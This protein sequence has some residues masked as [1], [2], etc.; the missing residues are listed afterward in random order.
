MKKYAIIFLATFMS[1]VLP[2]SVSAEMAALD[3]CVPP[4]QSPTEVARRWTPVLQYL[5]E[6]SG[7]L[8]QLKTAKDIPTY[9]QQVME[10]R[11]DIA[12]MS[13]NSYVAANKAGGYRAFAKEKGGKSF[14]LI[15][16]R[17]GGPIKQLSQL[18]GQTLAFPSS[19]A[20]MATILPLKQLEDEKV[21]VKIQYVVSI[22]SVY[23]SVAKGLF[24]AGGGEGR[25]FG[26]LDPEIRD[27]LAILWQSDDLP[28]FPFFA[29]PR[30]AAANLG[31]L[32]KTMIDMGQDADGQTLLRAVN[33]KALD[34][35]DDAEYEK[36]R[37]S[38]F[39]LEV[40]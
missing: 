30:V 11:C 19:T 26:A 38:N 40:K 14:S 16:A 8:L 25:T 15:V 17:K 13:P 33:I 28:P 12:Y 22:D 7:M 1:G 27:Q 24:V 34:I 37:R 32:Q 36:V 3:F 4:Q 20:F 10:G 5:S 21:A 31:K 18:S 23:R 35:A 6:K 39:P 2:S 9:Q 29:H